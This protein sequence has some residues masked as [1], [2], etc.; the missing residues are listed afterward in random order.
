V[1]ISARSIT[2][3]AP[4][5]GRLRFDLSTNAMPLDAIHTL[6]EERPDLNGIV[7]ATAH[8]ELQLDPAA[9]TTWRILS[10]DA[11]VTAKGLQL[12]GQP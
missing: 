3:A 11:D 9:K 7:Q 8:G 4:R 5:Y 2:S 10:L 6:S 1:R 12:T